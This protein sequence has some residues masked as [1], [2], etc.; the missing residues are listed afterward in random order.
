MNPAASTH[1]RSAFTLIV[2]MTAGLVLVGCGNSTP[3][4]QESTPTPS[5]SVTPVD[6]AI[7]WADGVC[8]AAAGIRG[9]VMAVGDDLQFDPSSPES[10]VDQIRTSLDARSTE[11]GAGIEELG[12]AIGSV[13]VDVPQALDFADTLNT[14]YTALTRSLEEAQT[15]IAAVTNSS[16]IV[17]FGLSAAAAVG[18][19]RAAIEATASLTSTLSLAAGGASNSVSTAFAES[20]TCKALSDGLPVPASTSAS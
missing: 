11:I 2:I 13:P 4:T 18:T 3:S 10:S 6:P 16:D 8:S 5:A 20:T 15:S 1:H 14:Q 9:S 7:I 17:S 19:I 12:T